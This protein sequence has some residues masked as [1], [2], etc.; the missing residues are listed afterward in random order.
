M[1]KAHARMKV[2]AI[3]GAAEGLDPFFLKSYG[4]TLPTTDGISLN[5]A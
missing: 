4:I 1:I 3:S 5:N 2:D